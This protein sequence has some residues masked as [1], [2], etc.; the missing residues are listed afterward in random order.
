[1]KLPFYPTDSFR[2]PPTLSANVQGK[3]FG[4]VGFCQAL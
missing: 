2:R 3:F 1:M 4:S